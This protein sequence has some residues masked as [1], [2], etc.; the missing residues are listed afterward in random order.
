MRARSTRPVA[1]VRERAILANAQHWSGSIESVMTRR[2]ATSLPPAMPARCLPYLAYIAYDPTTYRQFGIFVLELCSALGAVL[3][4]VKGQAAPETGFAF[5]RARELWEQLSFPAGYLH[6]PYGQSRYH[7]YR[8]EFDLATRLDEDLLRQSRQRNDSGGLVLAHQAC[9]SD[10]MLVG[11]FVS[12]RKH[13]EEALALYVPISHG[14]LAYQTGSHPQVVARAYLG[15]VLF[16]LGLPDQAVARTSAAIAEAQTL[17]HPASLASSLMVGAMLH[18]LAGE[19]GA[20][21]ERADN[22]VA[23]AIEQGVPWWR[24]VGTIYRGWVEANNGDVAKGISLLRSGS[25]AYRAT[26]AEMWMPYYTA[27]LARAYEIAG[28][29]EEALILL[30][31]AAQIV[32]RTGERWFAA[33]LYRHKGELLRQGDPETAEELYYKALS[34]AGEQEAKLWELRAEVSLARLRRDQGRRAEARDLLAPVYGWFSEGF[35]TPDLKD[36]KALLDELG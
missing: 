1:S 22:L 19:N 11:R 9:G 16:C 8:G 3:R 36:A 28:Q 12:S 35:D 7:G 32:G 18:S 4:F 2:A 5:A 30:E 20:L 25:A 13:Y 24:T 14:S 31:D 17:A 33:E 27:L 15:F 34:I 29:L 10:Q 6:I 21:G 23:V 26:G